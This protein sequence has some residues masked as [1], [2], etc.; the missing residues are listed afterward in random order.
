MEHRWGERV[1]LRLPVELTV[2]PGHR[3]RG[4]LR[5]ISVSGCRVESEVP[6]EGRHCAEIEVRVFTPSAPQAFVDLHGCIVRRTPTGFGVEWNELC[7][8]DLGALIGPQTMAGAAVRG[9]LSATA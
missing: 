7:P 9:R 6:T 2:S 8:P 4:W 3:I 1:D 5:D